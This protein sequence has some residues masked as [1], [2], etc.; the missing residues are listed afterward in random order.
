MRSFSLRTVEKLQHAAAKSPDLISS[1][2]D[3]SEATFTVLRRWLHRT[4]AGHTSLCMGLNSIL[5]I[6][7]KIAVSLERAINTQLPC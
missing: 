3:V 4:F 2:S 7:A 5:T 1:Y 6:F